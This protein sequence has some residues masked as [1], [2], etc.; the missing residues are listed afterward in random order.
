[1]TNYGWYVANDLYG[2]GRR[3]HVPLPVTPGEGPGVTSR[4]LGLRLYDT[5]GR[6]PNPADPHSPPWWNDGSNAARY[7][8]DLLGDLRSR[9]FTLRFAFATDRTNGAPFVAGD[10][11]GDT[12]DAQGKFVSGH[13]QWTPTIQ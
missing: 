5:G 13:P 9:A 8:D 10:V 1:M 2:D 6:G 4:M 7:R 12:L 11:W 3:L